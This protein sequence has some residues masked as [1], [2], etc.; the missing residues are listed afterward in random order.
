MC[1][2]NITIYRLPSDVEKMVFEMMRWQ[3]SVIFK[4]NWDDETKRVVRRQP[5]ISLKDIYTLIWVPVNNRWQV[6][7]N[8]ISS[9]DV[10]FKDVETL[11]AKFENRYDLIVREFEL[12]CGG[13]KKVANERLQ[14]VK[15]YHELDR[16][17]RG[18][19]LMSRL[20]GNFGLTG[21]FTMVESLLNLVQDKT[22]PLK[23]VTDELVHSGK[24]LEEITDKKM[25]C[26]DV[27]LKNKKFADWLKKS[28]SGPKEVKVLVDL[29]MISAAG[30]GDLEVHKVSCLH[31]AATA[32]A[33]LIYELQTTAGFQQFLPLC[34]QVWQ[35]L[36]VDPDLPKKFRDTS[37]QLEWLNRVKESHGS[38]EVNAL[39][40]ATAINAKGIYTVGTPKN[41]NGKRSLENIIQLKL[42]LEK[43][44]SEVETESINRDSVEVKEK[45]KFQTLNL[46][47]LNDLQSKLML[48]AGKAQE[49][50]KDVERFV[51]ILDG[52]TRL[53][54][55]YI[56]IC[57][58]GCTLFQNWR[59]HFYCDP[60][61]PVFAHVEFS[62]DGTRVINGKNSEVRGGV[63]DHILIL[64][65]FMEDCLKEWLTHISDQRSKSYYL[66]H[67]TTE[68]LVILQNELAKL[69]TEER[70]NISSKV[71]PVLSC[72]RNNCTIADLTKAMQET[73][74]RLLEQE[75]MVAQKDSKSTGM[76]ESMEMTESEDCKE[77]ASEQNQGNFDMFLQE[78]KDSGFSQKLANAALKAVGLDDVSEAI[79]WCM[80][81]MSNDDE[82]NDS[83]NEGPMVDYVMD[84]VDVPVKPIEYHG[85]QIKSSKESMTAELFMHSGNVQESLHT[86]L[87]K[88]WIDFQAE[89]D[90]SVADYLSVNH[91][92][93][94]LENL[95]RM[96]AVRLNRPLPNYLK[97]GKP[98][99]I[100]CSQAEVLSLVLSL[101]MHGEGAD[102]CLPGSDEV[103]MCNTSTTSE[104]IE[105]LWRRA[106]GDARTEH[107][108]KLYVLVHA[109][110]LDYEVSRRVEQSLE[111]HSHAAEDISLVVVCC[112]GEHEDRS[113]IINA[114]ERYRVRVPAVDI[115]EVQTYL[116]KHLT[117]DSTPKQYGNS[118][119]A[120]MLDPERCCVRVI[121][122]HRA[123]VG[124]TL[125]VQRLRD[126]IDK[127]KL[128]L[129]D[130]DG[131]LCTSIRLH[132]K[133]V[134][135]TEVLK[136]LLD[137]TLRPQQAVPRIFHIDI[138]Q[139][140]QEGVD[141]LLFNL[142]V[143]GSITDQEGYVWCRSPLDLYVI[144]TMP[145]M[146]RDTKQASDKVG[147]LKELQY[148]HHIFHLLPTITCWS[149]K[150]VLEILTNQQE[151]VKA[152]YSNSSLSNF[153]QK[154]DDKAFGSP[155]FQRPFQY[156]QRFAAGQELR[157]VECTHIQGNHQQ[158]IEILLAHCGIQDPS[159]AELRHFVNFLNV[160]LRASE[161]SVFCS[162]ILAPDLPGFLKFVVKFMMQMSKDFATRS[163]SISEETPE[164]AR[165]LFNQNDP[166]GADDEAGLVLYGL[167][168]R[169]ETRWVINVSMLLLSCLNIV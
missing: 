17:R 133:V 98:N 101:Y 145:L 106:E 107:C 112:G 108:G 39:A 15:N 150:D 56:K 86:R 97:K 41:L 57:N 75:Q 23:C 3:G 58:A 36:E 60:M 143:L 116:K 135:Q 80:I 19:E 118:R 89:M 7:C 100:I 162:D 104:E 125:K 27:F 18:A 156:L 141:Y 140:V 50:K 142:L 52:V 22:R 74:R 77:T 30:Q 93:M 109:E 105:L 111:K 134:R 11:S 54:N 38:V 79:N 83:D 6:I 20:K 2:P 91:L 35:K 90:T 63:V 88:L 64:C 21:D 5:Q 157:G 40:S 114:L 113:H 155:E 147:H 82:M 103:I 166:D 44:D 165:R 81:H 169:W 127:W 85:L 154:M 139:E 9:G 160:Q 122:S 84:V 161:Q 32:Y 78:L 94:F 137:H 138:A 146:Q 53:G 16:Y 59:A 102:L 69:N 25:E 151:A 65:E 158:C 159:W 10:T 120:S 132:C 70:T 119:T 46:Q 168:R 47:Q 149:P 71:Y 153:D 33:P 26:L 92:G 129:G 1:I 130:H 152:R 24:Q 49:G 55:V 126:E 164:V 45:E 123:G 96:N 8:Q 117:V 61:R 110:L 167:K 31:A 51:E 124:K 48:V 99:L 73:F 13:T 95:A 28:L 4:Q 76:D 43:D 29:A 87:K 68:Q 163:L 34:Q 72:V 128:P 115:T 42:R 121:K 131:T 37:R 144:E 67:Y 148:V 66:N 14:Q 136:T 62:G 12:M